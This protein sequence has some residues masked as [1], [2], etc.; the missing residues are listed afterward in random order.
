MDQG[1]NLDS[2][3]VAT[4]KIHSPKS[5]AVNI[6]QSPTITHAEW[7]SRNSS[8]DARMS[9]MDRCT[10]TFWGSQ[11]MESR[12][13][14]CR[15][16]LLAK[17]RHSVLLPAPEFP[18]TRMCIEGIILN[19]MLIDGQISLLWRLNSQ[20]FEHKLSSFRDRPRAVRRE[21]FGET[22]RLIAQRFRIPNQKFSRHASYKSRAVDGRFFQQVDGRGRSYFQFSF[23]KDGFPTSFAIADIDPFPFATL[24]PNHF[25]LELGTIGFGSNGWLN[26]LL[27]DLTKVGIKE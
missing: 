25:A 22:H 10:A 18:K 2:P 5:A 21:E 12:S 4:Y 19:G 7:A 8:S 15:E 9:F 14:C 11:T 27:G 13:R 23:E 16:Y 20:H 3:R 1:R 17:S 26:G 24:G 6:P